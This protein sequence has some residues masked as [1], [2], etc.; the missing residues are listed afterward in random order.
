MQRYT[1]KRSDEI[2]HEA[3]LVLE[4]PKGTA[5]NMFRAVRW[6]GG[7]SWKANKNIGMDG[8]FA[9]LTGKYETIERIE[10]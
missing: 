10:L 3:M 4:T 1:R 2:F 5:K 7:K 8:K 9:I 6:C